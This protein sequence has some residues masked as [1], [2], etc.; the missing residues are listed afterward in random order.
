MQPAGSAFTPSW[1]TIPE[2]C[3]LKYKLTVTPVPDNPTMID[4]EDDSEEVWV[5]TD[6]VYFNG[7]HTT[8]FYNPGTYVVEVRAWADN[9]YDTD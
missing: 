9:D 3:N 1:T 4:F 7:D 8:G 6:S 2:V 5:Q